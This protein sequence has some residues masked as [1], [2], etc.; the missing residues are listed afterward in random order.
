[1]SRLPDVLREVKKAG[2]DFHLDG[3]MPNPVLDKL[4][5]LLAPM[6]VTESIETG[7]GRTTLVLSHISSHHTVFSKDIGESQSRV[8]NSPLLNSDAVEFI[9]GA[10]QIN[11]PKHRFPR[12]QCAILDGPHAYPFPE[13][14]YYYV[15]PFL[16]PGA[17]LVID[18][19]CIP[20]IHRMYEVLKEDPMW[21]LESVVI[22]TAFLRRTDAPTFDPHGEGWNL[23][24]FN[25]RRFKGSEP[26]S[27]AVR[28]ALYRISPH[29]VR[30]LY[31][32]L[33]RPGDLGET[34]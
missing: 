21:R 10:S 7:C 3:T 18:D 19:I 30:R 28:R 16:D 15:Y 6:H 8:R 23:Q 9:E 25:A 34:R 1:M 29:F 31:A 17:L 20:T 24:P 27:Y 5:E 26:R 14:E 13:L 22:N 11:V 32:L 33:K 4:V 2:H 12:L